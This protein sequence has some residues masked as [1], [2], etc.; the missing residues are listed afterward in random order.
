MSEDVAKTVTECNTEKFNQEKRKRR[1]KKYRRA[2]DE[3]LLSSYDFLPIRLLTLFGM[4]VCLALF[5]FQIT[6][7]LHS[8]EVLYNM[9]AIEDRFP[10]YMFGLHGEP[11]LWSWDPDTE[12][13]KVN[14]TIF[15]H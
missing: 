1:K 9:A 14:T 10:D 5:I 12:L 3:F 15:I 11:N 6:T 13:L 2:K 8:Y 4:T 7:S